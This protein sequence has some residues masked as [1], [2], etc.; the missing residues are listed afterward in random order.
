MR[1]PGLPPPV[2]APAAA[3]SGKALWP[4][5]DSYYFDSY[6]RLQIKR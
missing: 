3:P 4:G 6:Q 2:K 5:D 1:H